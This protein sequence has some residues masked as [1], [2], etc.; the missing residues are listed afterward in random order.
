[1]NFKGWI[2]ALLIID[3]KDIFILSFTNGIIAGY[4]ITS[5]DK[6]FEIYKYDCKFYA[7]EYDISS[8]ILISAGIS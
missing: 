5:K 4:G 2:L 3:I 8:D 1:M 6:L 7:L